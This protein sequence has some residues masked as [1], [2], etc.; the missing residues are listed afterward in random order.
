MLREEPRIGTPLMREWL[1][2]YALVGLI[3]L[4]KGVFILILVYNS[5]PTNEARASNIM[6]DG[7]PATQFISSVGR[8]LEHS[9]NFIS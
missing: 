4:C 2:G 6:V 1:K 9:A 8:E 5:D 7:E 3:V